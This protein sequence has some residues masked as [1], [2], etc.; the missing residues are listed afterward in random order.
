MSEK[1]GK[2]PGST[3]VNGK[4]PRA[5][6]GVRIPYRKPNQKE[7]KKKANLENLALAG[8]KTGFFIFKG[9]QI[10]KQC[11]SKTKN[12]WL[13]TE[14]VHVEAFD[15]SH[16]KEQIKRSNIHFQNFWTRTCQYGSRTRCSCL[17]F[18]SVAGFC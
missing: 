3:K 1:W 14:R 11:F 2:G 9:L 4:A 17:Y 7:K 6:N 18:T 10:T 12:I 16:E 13:N 15:F 8:C 5:I